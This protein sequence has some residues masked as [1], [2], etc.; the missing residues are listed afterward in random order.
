[1]YITPSGP[2]FQMDTVNFTGV[3]RYHRVNI[4]L[5]PTS[6]AI[7]LYSKVPNDQY[8]GLT[9][10]KDIYEP[11]SMYEIVISGWGNT[12]SVIRFVFNHII[13]TLGNVIK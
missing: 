5:M 1:M 6:Q 8:I 7:L 12:R 4:N 10:S 9:Q 3:Y 2:T 11:N 13:F